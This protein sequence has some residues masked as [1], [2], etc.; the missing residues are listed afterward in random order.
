MCCWDRLAA[1]NSCS[2]QCHH[3]G[4]LMH[5]KW[6]ELNMLCWRAGKSSQKSSPAPWSTTERNNLETTSWYK[7]KQ[8]G[9]KLHGFFCEV[10]SAGQEE[11]FSTASLEEC[12]KMTSQAASLLRKGEGFHDDSERK[13]RETV[14]RG[15]KGLPMLNLKWQINFF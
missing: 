4:L 13:Y 8:R 9:K 1:L 6:K 3:T 2:E 5:N 15:N 7:H 10:F 11:R 14:G 12:C